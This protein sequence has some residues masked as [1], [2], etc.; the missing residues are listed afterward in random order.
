MIPVDLGDAALHGQA[1]NPKFGDGSDL[2]GKAVLACGKW[3]D[4]QPRTL[5]KGEKRPRNGWTVISGGA[6]HRLS[7]S[8]WSSF[9]HDDLRASEIF[10]LDLLSRRSTKWLRLVW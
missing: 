2:P 5:S 9:V 8:R 1:V 6:L 4:S 3:S 10:H 7:S